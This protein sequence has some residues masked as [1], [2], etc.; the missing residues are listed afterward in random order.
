[1]AVGDFGGSVDVSDSASNFDNLEIAAGGEV[2]TVG[3]GG[4]EFFGG[5]GHFDESTD[6]V[7]GKGTVVKITRTEASTLSGV[8]FQD[9]SRGLV[10]FCRAGR[11]LF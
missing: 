5:G 11:G 8:S 1:M 7:G 2:Q 6:A 9:E 4:E 10:M 3:S